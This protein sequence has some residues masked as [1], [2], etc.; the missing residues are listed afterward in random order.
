MPLSCASRSQEA[1]PFPFS[2]YEPAH[3]YSVTTPVQTRGSSYCI[4]TTSTTGRNPKK[5]FASKKTE[6]LTG[7]G[8]TI[9]WG[10]CF[11]NRF[12]KNQK[13]PEGLLLE[14]PSCLFLLLWCLLVQEFFWISF[15][16]SH[17][18]L[19]MLQ[20]TC[21]SH[22]LWHKSSFNG[23]VERN[24]ILVQKFFPAF[25]TKP[26]ALNLG[27]LSSTHLSVCSPTDMLRDYSLIFSFF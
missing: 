8:W 15:D 2:G 24:F 20:Q 6:I 4:N 5:H 21:Q 3:R 12:N 23:S 10:K 11:K 19:P 14:C 16:S 17:Y 13:Y 1:E 25:P 27:N 18:F 9:S 22:P 7:Q 26:H